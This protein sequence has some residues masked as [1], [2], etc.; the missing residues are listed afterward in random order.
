M[1]GTLRLTA[2][3]TERVR[4]SDWSGFTDFGGEAEVYA[5]KNEA[6]ISAVVR[7]AFEQGKKLRVVGLR[8]SWNALWHSEDVMMSTSRL[9][10]ITAI[11]P[12]NHTV[13]C[14]PPSPNDTERFGIEG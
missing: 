10:A 13:T 7:D 1:S 6:E 3:D 8:T 5:P 4:M 11:D 14:E 2:V 9:K 12:Q